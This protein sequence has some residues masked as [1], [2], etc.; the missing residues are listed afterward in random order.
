MYK[1]EQRDWVKNLIW[2]SVPESSMRTSSEGQLVQLIEKNKPKGSNKTLFETKL[3]LLSLRS[4]RI[5][6]LEQDSFRRKVL[7][8]KSLQSFPQHL[9][10]KKYGEK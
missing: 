5:Q 4:S 9:H 1:Q 3:I 2:S 8:L 10:H 7:I 6:N